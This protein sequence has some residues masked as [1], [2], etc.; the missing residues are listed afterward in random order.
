MTDAGTTRTPDPGD[1]DA[2]DPTQTRDPQGEDGRPDPAGEREAQERLANKVKAEKLN[3]LMA[4]HGASTPEELAERLA[5]PPAA[6]GHARDDDEDGYAQRRGA[7][8]AK[9]RA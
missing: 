2:A 5:Q 6:Q 7:R 9:A 4:Q 1:S 3:A 8:L